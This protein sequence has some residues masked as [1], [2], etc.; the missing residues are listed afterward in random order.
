MYCGLAAFLSLVLA[1]VICA[2]L[3]KDIFAGSFIAASVLSVAGVLVG[4][5][6][7]EERKLRIIAAAERKSQ[8]APPPPY[9]FVHLAAQLVFSSAMIAS[10]RLTKSDH[11]SCVSAFTSL[12]LAS[13]APSRRSVAR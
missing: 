5:E 13:S 1:G 9:A 3:G 4:I 8:A 7:P 10:Q 6:D 2:F 12:T 11:S